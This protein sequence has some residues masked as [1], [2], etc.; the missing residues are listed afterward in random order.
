MGIVMPAFKLGH[1]RVCR[2]E[3]LFPTHVRVLVSILTKEKHTS[4][5]FKDVFISKA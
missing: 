3:S 1:F 4:A 5:F 2:K